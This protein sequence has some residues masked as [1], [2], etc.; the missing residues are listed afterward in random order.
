MKLL[1]FKGR[2][3]RRLAKILKTNIYVYDIHTNTV[4]YG[5]FWEKVWEWID[6][7]IQKSHLYKW[8]NSFVNIILLCVSTQNTSPSWTWLE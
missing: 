5:E 2:R 1:C 7:N 6:L 8:L 3:G 4:T